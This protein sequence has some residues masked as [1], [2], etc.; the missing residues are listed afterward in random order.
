MTG[1]PLLNPYLQPP[2]PP[3]LAQSKTA[4]QENSNYASQAATFDSAPTGG[5]LLICVASAGGRAGSIGLVAPSGWST[6]FNQSYQYAGSSEE[7]AIAIFYKIAGASEGSTVTFTSTN[8]MR[9]SSITLMEW[10]N[11]KAASPLDVQT[12]NDETASTGLTANTGTT[13]TTTQAHVVAIAVCT[14]ADDNFSVPGSTDWTGS[15]TQIS[16]F[17]LNGAGGTPTDHTASVAYKI[18]TATGTQSTT[19]TLSGA[20]AQERYSGIAVFKGQLS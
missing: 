10:R 17:A 11:M 19:Q 15:Y 9:C 6:A 7:G 16:T 2:S 5:N 14:F 8:T 1:G 3:A 12:S 18:I 4:F 20:S 13:A